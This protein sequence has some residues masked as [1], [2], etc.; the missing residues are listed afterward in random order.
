MPFQMSG[1][2]QLVKPGGETTI[3]LLIRGISMGFQKDLDAIGGP[4][5]NTGPEEVRIFGP[6]RAVQG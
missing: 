3:F 4:G 1:L 2:F 5:G 6:D